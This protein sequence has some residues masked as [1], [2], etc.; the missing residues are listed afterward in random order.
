MPPG[1]AAPA[2]PRIGAGVGARRTGGERALGLQ[3]R[4]TASSGD[5]AGGVYWSPE[6]QAL[7]FRIIGVRSLMGSR[8]DVPSVGQP[9]TQVNLP[10]FEDSSV[11][12]E[13]ARGA[14]QRRQPEAQR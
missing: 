5:A 14:S 12:V 1:T 7:P 8:L 3:V 10:V 6:Q 9:G 2:A 11:R 13:P 4:S